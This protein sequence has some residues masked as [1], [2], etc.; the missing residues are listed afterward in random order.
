MTAPVEQFPYVPRDPSLGKASL[1]PHAA[2]DP[3]W[4]LK[5]HVFEPS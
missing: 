1:A 5:P 3:D 4:A 2:V